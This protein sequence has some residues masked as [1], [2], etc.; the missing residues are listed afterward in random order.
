MSEFSQ[1]QVDQLLK[2][3][4]G[5]DDFRKRYTELCA[6]RDAVEVKIA[7][8]RAELKEAQ[9]VAEEARVK[10]QAVAD[11]LSAARGGQKWFQLKKEIGLLAKALGGK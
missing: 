1:A 9:T 4:V 3:P 7:P 8:L 6:Y 11:K 10:C 5:L 2:K